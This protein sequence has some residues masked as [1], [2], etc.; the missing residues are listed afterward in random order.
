M[1]VCCVSGGATVEFVHSITNSWTVGTTTYYRHKVVI[2]NTSEK[3]ISDLKLEIQNL[4]GS[5]WG[6]SPTSEKN[7]Y[8]IPQ[9]LKVLNPGSVC[10]F[11][12]VQEGPQA[13]I[14]VLSYH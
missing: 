5:I 13:K 10:I 7:I 2:K 12:Y 6:L 4:S 9:W 1:N 14:S 8:E 11:V 3:P